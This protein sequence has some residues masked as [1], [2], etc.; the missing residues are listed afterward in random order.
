MTNERETDELH[1]HLQSRIPAPSPGYWDNIDMRLR[2]STEESGGQDDQ[3]VVGPD[4]PVPG[5]LPLGTPDGPE[6]SS[7]GPLAALLA[8]RNLLAAAAVVLLVGVGI[9]A[10]EVQQL[11]T[12]LV[13]DVVVDVR[14]EHH[15]AVLQQPIE[16]CRSR[17]EAGFE[18]DR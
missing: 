5:S 7:P 16:H 13:G 18:S 6:A 9:F 4:T 1:K 11:C 8:N 15:D 2:I 3:R 17:I 12:D 14:A 10:F